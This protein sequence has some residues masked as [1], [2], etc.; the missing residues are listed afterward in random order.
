MTENLQ[1]AVNDIGKYAFM[2]EN[3]TW[4]AE[5]ICRYAIFEDVYLQSSSTATD[6]LQRA[7]VEF[8]ATIMIYLSKSKGYFDQNTIC[9]FAVRTVENI[10]ITFTARR[11]ESGLLPKSNIESY[12]DAIATAQSTVDRCANLAGMQS[13]YAP[14]PAVFFI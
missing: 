5:I 14:L 3:L 9:R 12:F 2:V 11:L 6:E 1:I 8:Y 4:I 7:L 10:L 13:K